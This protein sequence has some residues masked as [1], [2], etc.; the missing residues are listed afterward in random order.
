[1][2]ETR[3]YQIVS[4]GSCDLSEEDILKNNL[5]V[6]PFYVSFKEGEYLKEIKEVSVRDFYEKMVKNKGVFPKTSM[7]STQDYLEVFNSLAKENIDIICLCITTKFSGSFNSAMTAKNLCLEE[8]P[9]ANIEIIDTMINTVLQ[10]MLVKETCLMQQNDLNFN[11]VI[12]K[13]NEIKT[14]GRIFFTVNGLAYL[15]H[16]GRIGKLTALIGNVLKINPLIN[17]REGEIFSCGISLSR[18]RALVKVRELVKS[19]FSKNKLNIEDYNFAV[20]YGYDFNESVIFRDKLALDLNID[21]DSI[22]IEQIGATI[23]VHTGPYPLG[24]GLIK[25]FNK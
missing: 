10:G 22:S 16:G 13:V 6:V 14:T 11:E 21:K 12:N 4:D 3:K 5:I 23:A 7:P 9:N 20:G 8:Y 19:H 25:K 1:M 15:Q 18:K 17:L 24:V 2:I